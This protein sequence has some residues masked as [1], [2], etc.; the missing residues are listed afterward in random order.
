MCN[1]TNQAKNNSDVCNDAGSSPGHVTGPEVEC[2]NQELH[3][4]HPL[5][6]SPVLPKLE[7]LTSYQLLS[8]ADNTLV[9]YMV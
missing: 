9:L 5:R 7:N 6:E 3:Q 2:Q 4:L 1:K 8:G